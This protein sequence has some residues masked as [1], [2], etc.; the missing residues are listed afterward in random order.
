MHEKIEYRGF[1]IVW[2][3]P[4]GGKW[5]AD[6]AAGS[7]SLFPAVSPDQAK[8][9]HGHNRDDMLSNAKL[10]IDEL[11]HQRSTALAV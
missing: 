3:K 6:I 10:Y 5:A 9:I 7:P 1:F 11:L 8:A 2:R 4:D